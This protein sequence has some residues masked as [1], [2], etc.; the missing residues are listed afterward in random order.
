MTTISGPSIQV[1]HLTGL[2]DFLTARTWALSEDTSRDEHGYPDDPEAMWCYTSS[3]GGVV[4]HD[5]GDITPFQLSCR[6]SFRA[7]LSIA[8]ESAGNFQGCP[9]HT[10]VEHYIDVEDAGET[11]RDADICTDLDLGTLGALLA[12]LEPQASA[13]DPR[14][15]IECR[16]FGP[17]G[18]TFRGI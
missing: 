18:E 1:A 17:C 9:A 4:M 8:V 12:T 15:L 2:H 13:L 6:F 16:F 5:L 11:D 14:Q 10:Q 3:F 7:T